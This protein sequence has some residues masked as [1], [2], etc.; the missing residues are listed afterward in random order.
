MSISQGNWTIRVCACAGACLLWCANPDAAVALESIPPA[1]A[2]L[3]QELEKILDSE[4]ATLSRTNAESTA[5]GPLLSTDLL[6][7]NANRGPAL[8]RPDTLDTVRL[9][10]DRFKEI[11]IQSVK[12]AVQYPLLRPDFPQAAEYL[13]FY[14]QV[15]KEAHT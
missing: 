3:Y 5:P 2:P 12:F 14:R 7:A 1:Y 15:V 10:L 11:G 6:A 4:L 13:E 9:S 8:L